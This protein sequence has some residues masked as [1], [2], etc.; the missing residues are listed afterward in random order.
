MNRLSVVL[1]YILHETSWKAVWLILAFAVVFHL[2]WL[3]GLC[4][5]FGYIVFEQLE[6]LRKR[7]RIEYDLDCWEQD[8]DDPEWENK[9]NLSRRKLSG[10]TQF[11][12][13][14]IGSLL[15]G[16]P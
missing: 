8:P 14:R 2:S 6:H 10:E 5:L 9:G 13:Y 3:K 4:I 12:W 7:N 1:W 11:L 16:L 15:R